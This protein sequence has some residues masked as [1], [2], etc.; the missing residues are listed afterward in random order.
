MR[1]LYSRLM[2]LFYWVSV[3]I[4]IVSVVIMTLLVGVGVYLRYVHGMGAFAEPVS[5]FLAI[6]LAFYGAAACYRANAHLSLNLFVRLLPGPLKGIDRWLVY[7]MMATISMAMIYY[8][9]GLVQ[10][11]LGQKYPEFQYIPILNQVTVGVA[12]TAIPVSGLFTLLFVLEKIICG[13]AGPAVDT[14]E[15]AEEAL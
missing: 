11:T 3:S 10:T 14:E 5:I 4:A 7:L 1:I 12:Y 9:V 13:D 15:L 6:Q 2:S 8:G